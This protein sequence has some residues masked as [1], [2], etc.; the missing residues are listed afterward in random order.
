MSKL[1]WRSPE[2]Y[3]NMQNAEAADF[4][5][6]CLRRN[7]DYQTEYRA[8]RADPTVVTAGFRSKWGLSFRS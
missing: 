4:A 8:L 2:A 3:K 6:E 7:N 1:D 5:W